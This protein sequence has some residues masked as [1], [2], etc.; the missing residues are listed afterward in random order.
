MPGP[1]EII[2]KW[3]GQKIGNALTSKKQNN[4][5]GRSTTQ[6]PQSYNLRLENENF[7][8]LYNSDL[9]DN[10]QRQELKEILA[11]NSL[12]DMEKIYSWGVILFN[13]KKFV[14]AVFCFELVTKYNDLHSEAWNYRAVILLRNNQL[15][16]AD[17]CFHKAVEVDDSN[18]SA[19]EN[20][21]YFKQGNYPDIFK[22]YGI[23]V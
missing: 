19:L 8:L 20:L 2:G 17:N 6:L 7:N 16:P 12:D 13:E 15:T 11:I 4:M 9:S 21:S 5:S 1:G 22:K 23:K 10:D 18:N 14:H 3:L